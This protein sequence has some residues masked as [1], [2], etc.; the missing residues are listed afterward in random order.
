MVYNSLILSGTDLFG[1]F[2]YT[3]DAYNLGTLPTDS[4]AS[5]CT[6]SYTFNYDAVVVIYSLVFILSLAGNSL[7][8]LVIRCSKNLRSSTDIYLLNLAIADLLFAFI[9]PF[10]AV[11]NKNQ[12]IFGEFMCKAISVLREVNFYSGILLLVCISIDRYL[13]IVHATQSINHKRHLVKYV[14]IVIWIFAL[15]LSLPIILFRSVFNSPSSGRLICSENAGAE[16]TSSLRNVIRF[17]RH[18]LGFFF[19]LVVMLFCYG[20]TI[21]TLLQTRSGQKHKA[22][23]IIFAVV[24]VFLICWLPYNVSIFFDT[25]MRTQVIN[26]TC[27]M[28]DH[29]DNVLIWTEILSFM[30]C[31]INPILYAFIGQKFRHSLLKIMANYGLIS[32]DKI[33]KS[34]SYV[35]TTGNTSTT[36]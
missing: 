28:R 21:K 3:D 6:S 26:E 7:V 32:K 23:K 2:N 12:W 29:V 8:V 15:L 20:S 36:V 13:A 17:L 10:W 22:M 33:R 35:S 11:Y 19:P 34:S 16:A 24:L 14:C 27:S 30:H 4:I 5:P 18:T 9:L 31:C 1:L 25:L